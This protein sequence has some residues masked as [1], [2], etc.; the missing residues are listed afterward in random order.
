[1]TKKELKNFYNFANTQNKDII[2]LNEKK[3][4]QEE[5]LALNQT[6]KNIN[7]AFLSYS[8]AVEKFDSSFN[9]ERSFLTKIFEISSSIMQN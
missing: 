2:E 5:V 3:L 4:Y 8:K 6:M 1:M 9:V 7:E